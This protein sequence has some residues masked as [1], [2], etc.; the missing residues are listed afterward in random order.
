MNF[1]PLVAAAAL[2]V[3]ALT[4]QATTIG[5]KVDTSPANGFDFFAS[6]FDTGAGSAFDITGSLS[7]TAGASVTSPDSVNVSLT[8]LAGTTGTTGSPFV[9]ATGSGGSYTFALN[10]VAA[11]QYKLWVYGTNDTSTR[12]LSGSYSVTAVP[13]PETYAMLLA[14]LGA[15]GL[16]ARRRKA[17]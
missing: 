7:F 5:S 16:M 13:E 2:S 3:A 4:A 6:S 9:V 8:N 10:N 17:S 14:G 15:L 12:L 11:G 1:N